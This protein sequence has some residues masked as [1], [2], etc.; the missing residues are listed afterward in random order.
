[1]KKSVKIEMLWHLDKL[2]L[3]FPVTIITTVDS[4]GNI[5]A[6]PYSL[7]MPWC[8]SP[9]NPQFMLSC[10]KAWHTPRNIEA[11]G[12]FVVNYPTSSL[13]EKVA[14]TGRFYPEGINELDYAGLNAIPS[15]KVSPPRIEECYQHIECRVNEKF[16]PSS[17]QVT[18]IADILD[19]SI[20]EEFLEMERIERIKAM[21]LPIYFGTN[22]IGGSIFGIVGSYETYSPDIKPKIEEK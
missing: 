8:A 21:D 5:N 12:E 15:E 10:N 4:D 7:A 2:I 13:C 22:K 20:N 1:M 3:P 16:Y 11:N 9:K 17:T 18:F 6:A 19:I 14:E